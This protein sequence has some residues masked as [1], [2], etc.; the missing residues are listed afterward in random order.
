MARNGPPRATTVRSYSR[1]EE[2]DD[3]GEDVDEGRR[4]KDEN[5][6]EVVVITG[7]GRGLGECV[8]GIYGI[9]GTAVAV[10]DLEAEKGDGEMEGVRMYQCD[11]GNRAE[12]ESVWARVVADVR[13]SFCWGASAFESGRERDPDWSKERLTFSLLEFSSGHRLF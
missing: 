1:D 5:D 7:G 6:E 12:V 10:L 3:E 8:A 9:K 2:E 4:M 13:L 11:V